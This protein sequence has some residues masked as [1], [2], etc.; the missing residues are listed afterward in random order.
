MTIHDKLHLH[1]QEILALAT[2]HGAS[3]VRV[4][5]SVARGEADDRSDLDLLVEMA[6][7]RSLFDMGALLVALEELLGCSVDLVTEAGMHEAMRQRV[8]VEAMPLEELAA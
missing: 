4:F 7:G 2:R 6:P 3:K 5:G 8:M 1:R